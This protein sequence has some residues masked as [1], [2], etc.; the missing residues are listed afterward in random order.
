[1]ATGGDNVVDR[2]AAA[3]S[4]NRVAEPELPSG[5]LPTDDSD[6]RV[7]EPELPSGFLPSDD[8]EYIEGKGCIGG[9]GGNGGK[10]R[11]RQNA[12]GVPRWQAPGKG[13]P[14]DP[15]KLQRQRQ[16]LANEQT[17]GYQ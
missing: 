8:S 13:G 7:A 14:R 15:G 4:H 11:P 3:D 9:K 6:N 10:G 16:R 12:N 17:W 1:M 2:S 5:F